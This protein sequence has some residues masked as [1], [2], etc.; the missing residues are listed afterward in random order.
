MQAFLSIVRDAC[1]TQIWS[2]AVQLARAGAVS[3]DR[4][5]GGEVHLR[6]ATRGG[7]IS[8]NVVLYLND[9]DWE[10]TCNGP[11]E[12][13]EHI[14]AAA[15]ALRQARKD[16]LDLPAPKSSSGRI[17]YCFR[18]ENHTLCLEREVVSDGSAQ[19][20]KST[21]DAIA[22]GRVAGPSFAADQRDLRAEVVLGSQRRGPMSTGVME[23]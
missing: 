7:L 22:S 14:A 16:G 21:L 3:G 8:P 12:P 15:I 9:E 2:R 13:C 20:L 4:D 19:T 6:V 23:S 5:E 1:S 11:D 10:C 17:R 18:R